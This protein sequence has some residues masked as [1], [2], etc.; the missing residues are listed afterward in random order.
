VQVVL[1]EEGLTTRPYRISLV[2]IYG[3]YSLLVTDFP[4]RSKLKLVKSFLNHIFLKLAICLKIWFG[5]FSCSYM[6][7]KRNPIF[8]ES[9]SAWTRFLLICVTIN[10][11]ISLAIL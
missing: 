10:T 2:S 3:N 11:S 1:V 8:L 5:F 4:F 9:N 6:K 7:F